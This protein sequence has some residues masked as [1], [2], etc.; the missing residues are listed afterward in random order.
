[1]YKVNITS[2]T[3]LQ[4]FCLAK[5]VTGFSGFWNLYFL[6][7]FWLSLLFKFTFTLVLVTRTWLPGVVSLFLVSLPKY[8]YHPTEDT[9]LLPATPLQENVQ[10]CSVRNNSVAVSVRRT[11]FMLQKKFRSYVPHS[12]ASDF[13]SSSSTTATTDF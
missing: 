2:V 12:L 6:K 11:L 7:H 1:M 4:A 9:P 8:P 10:I 3:V 13:C 5:T